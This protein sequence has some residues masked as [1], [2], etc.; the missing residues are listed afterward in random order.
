M[1][2][3]NKEDGTPSGKLVWR[4]WIPV[5]EQ[6]RASRYRDSGARLQTEQRE[7]AT[8]TAVAA[9]KK[10]FKAALDDVLSADGE[11]NLSALC[12]RD[13]AEPSGLNAIAHCKAAAK[14]KPAAKAAARHAVT[15]ID[16]AIGKCT[17]IVT[18]ASKVRKVTLRDFNTAEEKVKKALEACHLVLGVAADDISEEA[19]SGS[20][21]VCHA[22]Q[23]YEGANKYLQVIINRYL[24]VH[25]MSTEL[26]KKDTENEAVAK[27]VLKLVLDRGDQ[28]LT[29]KGLLTEELHTLGYMRHVLSS[30]DLL[31]S[32]ESVRALQI[33]SVQETYLGADYQ[34]P[35][36]QG[37][38]DSH[39]CLPV[40]VSGC[41]VGEG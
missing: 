36:L 28:Y 8:P 33:L 37:H 6:A 24:M 19:G 12:L 4:V 27:G 11:L 30:L 2:P 26:A 32:V 9:I 34:Q 3:L 39:E 31:D 13:A 25:M 1:L 38:G 18:A 7:K 20:G 17:C 5:K 14:A 22:C 29:E 35:V 21:H 15:A 40:Q 10:N 23:D 16:K 41:G